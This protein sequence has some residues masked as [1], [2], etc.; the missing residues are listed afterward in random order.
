MKAAWTKKL[1]GPMKAHLKARL[2]SRRDAL[3]AAEPQHTEMARTQLTPKIQLKEVER[4]V[5]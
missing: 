1:T 3:G 2:T 4:R 5:R